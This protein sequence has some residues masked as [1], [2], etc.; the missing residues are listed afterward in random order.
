MM[1]HGA[2]QSN[3]VYLLSA[4]EVIFGKMGYTEKIGE[5]TAAATNVYAEAFA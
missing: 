5:A 2:Q 1:G 4:L 3:V